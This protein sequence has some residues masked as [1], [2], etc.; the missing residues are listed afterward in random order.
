MFLANFLLASSISLP[1]SVELKLL[2][3]NQESLKF[4][5]QFSS[6]YLTTYLWESFPGSKLV[7]AH[8]MVSNLTQ[9]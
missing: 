3:T 8:V 9:F 4:P 2:G 1:T 7:K 6:I 5:Q